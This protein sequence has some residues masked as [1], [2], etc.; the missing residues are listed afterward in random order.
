MPIVLFCRLKVGGSIETIGTTCELDG[1]EFFDDISVANGEW[2]TFDVHWLVKPNLS[3]NGVEIVDIQRT[4]Q[5]FS[6]D[7]RILLK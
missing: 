5:A 1:A 3:C 6:I 2:S 4:T 7:Q